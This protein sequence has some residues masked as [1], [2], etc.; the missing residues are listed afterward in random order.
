MYKNGKTFVIYF[1]MNICWILFW[2][3]IRKIKQ[4]INPKTLSLK[5]TFLLKNL[6]L[7]KDLE[8]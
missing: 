1:M 5:A 3:K 8:N 4:V 7:R 6:Y 2:Y